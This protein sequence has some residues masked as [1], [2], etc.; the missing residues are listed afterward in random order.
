MTD[1]SH[2]S[3]P[4]L[5]LE[6]AL[7]HCDAAIPNAL[8]T[9]MRFHRETM[10][11]ERVYSTMPNAYPISGRKPK[12]ES[13]WGQ[14]VLIEKQ[15]NC[16][17]GADDIAWAFDDH[18]KILGLGLNAVLNVPVIAG[19]QVIGTINFLRKAPPF[20]AVE[21]AFGKACAEALAERR[22]I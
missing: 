21:I 14:K 17:F 22:K 19:N 5:T 7:A 2:L 6:E 13:A 9:A 11:V 10:E 12:R 8:F 18:A 16:G 20:S 3:S 1:F 4:A 15:T